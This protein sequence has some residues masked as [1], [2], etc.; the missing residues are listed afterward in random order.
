MRL[1][2]ALLLSCGLAD[3]QPMNKCRL[4][5]LMIQATKGKTNGLS[6]RNVMAKSE[7]QFFN[8]PD[9]DGRCRKTEVT[10]VPCFPS[11]QLSALWRR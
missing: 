4:Q 8:I 10:T 3:S 6:D 7:S 11:N 5:D 9:L 1:L 2:L